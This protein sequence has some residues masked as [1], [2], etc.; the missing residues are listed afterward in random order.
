MVVIRLLLTVL[1]VI[2]LLAAAAPLVQDARQQSAERAADRSISRIRGVIGELTAR[3]DPTPYS[4][5]A[6][7]T[8]TLAIPD[9]SPGSVGIDW[10]AI[11]GVP[12][13]SGPEEPPGTDVIAYSVDGTVHVIR[14]SSIELR[15]R[16]DD[17]RRPDHTPF[18]LRN[19]RALRFTY[20]TVEGRPVI[21]VAAQHS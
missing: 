14:L 16:I 15:V 12:G 11:G 10:I 20:R 7:R 13:R 4:P 1:I 6:G 19:S 5:G 18:V 21:I 9:A 8:L 3:S 2:A 17:R